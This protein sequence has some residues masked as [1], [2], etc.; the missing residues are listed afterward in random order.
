[1]KVAHRLL[2]ISVYPDD[3]RRMDELVRLLRARGVKYASRSGLVRYA[4]TLVD[5][6]VVPKSVMIPR[7]WS[8]PP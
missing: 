2:C 4:L 8:K 5:P 3:I 1:M 7:G 6:E